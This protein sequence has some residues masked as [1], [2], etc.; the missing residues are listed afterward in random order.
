MPGITLHRTKGESRM[1]TARGIRVYMLLSFLF[2]MAILLQRSDAAE[3]GNFQGVL[4]SSGRSADIPES[5]DLYGWLV[6]SWEMEPIGVT[7]PRISG[8]VHFGRVLEGRAV[9]DVWIWPRRA[10]R[11]G[12]L[13]KNVNTYGSTMRMWDPELKAWRVTWLNP[14][15]GRASTLIGRRVGA[16]IMQV[17]TDSTGATIR[18]SFVDIK[19][20]S[21]RWTGETLEP[22]GRTWK[23][24]GDF[25]GKRIR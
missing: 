3:P 25:R 14:L 2:L 9:Q 5:E 20:D 11:Q 21:F 10:E 23:M 13:D 15:N 16:D 19:P 12:A 1:I 7:T 8:E 24:S 4:I 6:G 22:D 17:G 18:W